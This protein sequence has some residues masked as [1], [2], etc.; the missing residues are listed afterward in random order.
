MSGMMPSLTILS[1]EQ[2]FNGDNLLQWTTNLEQLLGAKGLMGYVNGKIPKPTE[3]ATSA[4]TITS[5]PIYSTTP[6]LD[7]WNFRDQLTRGHITLNCTDIASLGVITTGTAKEAWDSIKNEWGKSTDMRRSH[8]QESLNRTEYIEGNEIQDHIK[9][10]R[11][12]KAA[13]DNLSTSTMSDETWRGIIIRSIPPTTK[14]LPVI[15]SLYSMTTSADIVSTLVA[16]GMILGRETKTF[17]TAPP[18]TTALATHTNDGC[19]NINCKAKD[20]SKHTTENCYWPGGGKE[21]QFPENFGQRS[22]A[23]I[24]TTSP[25]Q[26]EHFVLS[27]RV[28]GI[29]GRSGILFDSDD[30]DA[31]SVGE[32]VPIPIDPDINIPLDPLT[33]I[34]RLDPDI[35]IPLNRDPDIN[36]F[37]YYVSARTSLAA[38]DD[39][40]I[41]VY[42]GLGITDDLDTQ[43]GTTTTRDI[44]NS[45]INQTTTTMTIIPQV[46]HHDSDHHKRATD[47]AIQSGTTGITVAHHDID[48]H[49][50]SD[51]QQNIPVISIGFKSQIAR[52]MI[53]SSITTFA[54]RRYSLQS[55]STED[56][57]I[58]FPPV[59]SLFLE[60]PPHFNFRT[61]YDHWHPLF[62]NINNYLYF[63]RKLHFMTTKSS[64]PP[65][66]YYTVYTLHF[67]NF[68]DHSP[69]AATIRVASL[70]SAIIATTFQTDI[71]DTTHH[72]GYGLADLILIT[73]I[74]S[75]FSSSSASLAVLSNDPSSVHG[76][77]LEYDRITGSL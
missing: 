75:I 42:L 73:T 53:Q 26:T 38:L 27:A 25:Q 72:L 57:G 41:Q 4:Q 63:P 37:R 71:I 24:T 49:H 14:W 77:V 44:I 7:E 2:K 70:T 11:T 48:T 35:N 36:R 22:K 46:V 10:L 67:R 28:T 20:R 68:D 17:T 29:F 8:A 50:K 64:Y 33:D 34:N 23:N 39:H 1:E 58:S 56:S 54:G 61:H 9:L 19:K 45:D 40:D 43:A 59:P 55:L 30:P 12:R 51:H 15:P 52:T 5:T 62:Q 16:H 47:S 69:A 76:G 31:S 3:P 66:A 18:S 32:K 60:M 6:T 74:F 65:L 13:V 21:G